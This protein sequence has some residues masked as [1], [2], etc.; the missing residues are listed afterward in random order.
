MIFANKQSDDNFEIGTDGNLSVVLEEFLR[1][2]W[3]CVTSSY[4]VN[5]LILNCFSR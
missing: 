5:A 1:F 4:L 3:Q 2:F